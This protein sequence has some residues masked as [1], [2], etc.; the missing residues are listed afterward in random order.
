MNWRQWKLG[1]VVAGATGALAG[2]VGLAVGVS[3]KQAGWILA[4]SVGKDLLLYLTDSSYRAKVLCSL[5]LN[6]NDATGQAPPTETKP[7]QKENV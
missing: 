4:I 5:P 7:G 3:W 6:G 1:L 2:L